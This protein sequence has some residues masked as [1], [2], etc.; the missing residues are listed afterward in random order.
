MSPRVYGLIST[1]LSEKSLAFAYVRAKGAS[2]PWYC[3][4]WENLR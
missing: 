1:S 2:A 3:D 4:E